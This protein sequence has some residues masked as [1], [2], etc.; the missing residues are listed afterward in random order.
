MDTPTP[1]DYYDIT[2]VQSEPATL[3]VYQYAVRV[4][5]IAMET[6]ELSHTEAAAAFADPAHP[7]AAEIETARSK[8]TTDLERTRR[9]YDVETE[10]VNPDTIETTTR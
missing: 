3:H 1:A 8:S 6:L 5:E 7:T 10:T 4:T 2:N 9:W